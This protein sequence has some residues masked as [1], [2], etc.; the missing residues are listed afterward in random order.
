[1]I[2]SYIISLN[3]PYDL[4]DKVKKYNLKPILSKGISGK[5]LTNEEIRLNTKNKVS[6]LFC[7]KSVLGCALAHLKVWN[8]FL[9]SNKDFCIIFEDDVVFENNFEEELQNAL[10]NAPKNFDMLFL[11]CIGCDKKYSFIYK[12]TLLFKNSKKKEY[13]KINKYINK[14]HF[15]VGL[16]A[17]IISKKGAEKL[18]KNIKENIY[19]HI[20]VMIYNLY[21]EEKINIYSLN[22]RIAYQTSTSTCKSLNAVDYPYLF[23]KFLSNFEV[24]K[25]VSLN[26]CSSLSLFRI[27]N[28]NVSLTTILFFIIGVVLALFKVNLMY[29]TIGFLLISFPDILHGNN[30]D[31]MIIYYF[32]LILPTIMILILNRQNIQI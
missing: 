2:D 3:E 7:P 11:G 4:L 30:F 25:M 32:I 24:D 22:R 19:D 31:I 14:P 28:F 23:N 5:N 1:M 8:T 17:Y 26:Y 29:I 13:K 27:H 6:E 21:T 9:E 18:I 10:K 12:L 16:N 20:D 15:A